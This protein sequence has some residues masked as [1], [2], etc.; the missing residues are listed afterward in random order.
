MMSFLQ[1]ESFASDLEHFARHAK[2]ATIQPEEYLFP[3]LYSISLSRQ[4]M[5]LARLVT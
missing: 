4:L 2:R 3:K 1:A 5:L